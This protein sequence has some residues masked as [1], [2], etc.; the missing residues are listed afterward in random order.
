MAKTLSFATIHFGVAFGVGYALTG[1]AAIGSAIALIEPACN[2]ASGS[3]SRYFT[4]IST[5]LG[6]FMQDGGETLKIIR[7]RFGYAIRLVDR[8]RRIA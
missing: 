4:R 1:S 3:I 2:T 8:N 7:K 6:S 5:R